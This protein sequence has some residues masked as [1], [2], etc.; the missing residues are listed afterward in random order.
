M[1]SNTHA[2]QNM[3]Y[4]PTV[5]IPAPVPPQPVPQQQ[6]QQLQHHPLPNEPWNVPPA[7]VIPA[8]HLHIQPHTLHN[9]QPIHLQHQQL[10]NN[11]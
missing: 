2:T 9:M 8:N 10:I 4:V 11:K 6:Q 5:P 7:S 1:K 3:N